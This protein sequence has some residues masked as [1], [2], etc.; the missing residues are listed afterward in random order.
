MTEGLRLHPIPEKKSKRGAVKK[1]KPQNLLL[2]FID[3]IRRLKVM[4][5]ISGCFRSKQGAADFSDIRSY[6]AITK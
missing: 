1:S 3:H 5:K 4:Q 2:R 6:I